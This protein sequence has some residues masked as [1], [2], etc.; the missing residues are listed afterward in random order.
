MTGTAPIGWLAIIRLG[1]VQSALG[2]IVMLTTSMLNR[3]MIVEY[4]L[5]A[6]IPAALIAWH[7]GV[8]LA[9]PAWGHASDRGGRRTAWI[10]A[11][12]G[13]LAM[14]ALLATSAVLLMGGMRWIGIML[15]VVAFSMIGAGVGAAGT[16]LLALLAS[17]VAPERRPAAAAIAWIMMVAG[18]VITAGVAGSLLDPF[19]PQRLANVAGFVVLGAFLLSLLAVRGMETSREF[20][21][22]P[23]SRGSFAEALRET[24][25]DQRARRFSI[26]VFVSMLAYS[27]QDVILEPFAGLVFGYTPG[28]STQLSSFQHM[29]VLI[30]LVVG[31]VTGS[32]FFGPIKGGLRAWVVAGCLGSALMLALLGFAATAGP[33]WPLRSTVFLLGF[34]NGIFAVSAIAGMM[35]LAGGAGPGKEGIRMGI[36][37][38]A[39]AIAFGLGGLLGAIGLDLGRVALGNTQLAF[40]LVFAVEAA[41]FLIAAALAIRIG[42]NAASLQTRFNESALA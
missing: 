17:R 24:W 10:V 19:T 2:A 26:F 42:S 14:G 15:A 36:W 37:G 28:Q 11:G 30:G 23:I 29:G 13:L 40:V 34:A 12:M 16:S 33:G 8:Q 9:R 39:Q 22:V 7:Y 5:A 4:G 18:I 1:L 38:A 35:E 31:G 20:A 32:G 3:I 41:L 6:T 21:P 25:A 27:M